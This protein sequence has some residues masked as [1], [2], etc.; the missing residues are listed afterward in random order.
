VERV[1]HPQKLGDRLS[2]PDEHDLSFVLLFDGWP[3]DLERFHASALRHVSSD[4]EVVVVDNPVDDEASGRIARL[5]RVLHIPLR[6]RVG[7]AAGRNLGLRLASGRVV[8]IVDTSV[9]IDGPLA[10]PDPEGL[11]GKW[12]VVATE[13]IYHFEASDGP[14]VAGVEA[15][16]MAMRREILRTTGLFDPKF[17]WYR[18]AD[19]DFSFQVRSH[20]FPTIVDPSLPLVRHE[21]R[22][23]ETTPEPEREESSRKNFFRFR[24]HWTD[25]EDLLR[26]T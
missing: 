9:E 11:L 14:A 22:L 25:R 1:R 16:F 17:K 18:N 12:G 2:D 26:P 7:W 10:L 6:D 21:H 23:W 3:E 8:C 24:D 20:G 5:D 4:F 19:L 13:N 15:Y